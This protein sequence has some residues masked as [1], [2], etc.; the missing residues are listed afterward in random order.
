MQVVMILNIRM[1]AI[2]DLHQENGKLVKVDL[3][4]G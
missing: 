4:R 1:V 2:L 3:H